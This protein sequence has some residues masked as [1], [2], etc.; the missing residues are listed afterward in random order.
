MEGADLYA[1]H[2]E[3]MLPHRVCDLRIGL[4]SERRAPFTGALTA[5]SR[6]I[7]QLDAAA[8]FAMLCFNVTELTCRFPHVRPLHALSV[9]V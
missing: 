5:G 9:H 1:R 7:S 4:A 2:T 6:Y 3:Y 8:G